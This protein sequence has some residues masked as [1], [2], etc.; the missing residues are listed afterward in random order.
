MR[1]NL[2]GVSEE[3][4]KTPVTSDNSFASRQTF[5]YNKSVRVSFKQNCLIQDNISCT[6]RN[7]VN[8]F[9]FKKLDTW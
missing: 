4:I 9:I 2:K 5:V 6:H 7:A 8:L 3:S 1:E